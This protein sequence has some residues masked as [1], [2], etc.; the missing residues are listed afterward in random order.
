MDECLKDGVCRLVDALTLVLALDPLWLAE[1]GED[2]FSGGLEVVLLGV[3]V[4]LAA[5]Y[6]RASRASACLLG[7]AVRNE[8]RCSVRLY[9][10]CVSA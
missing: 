7:E 9:N 5:A 1:E 10:R 3:I 8:W 4:C 6:K 2:L